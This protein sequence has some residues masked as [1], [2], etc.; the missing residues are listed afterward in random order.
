MPRVLLVEDE[1]D[2]RDLYA[3]YLREGGYEVLE[4]EDGVKGLDLALEGNWDIM[5]LDIML[6]SQDGIAVLKKIKS[7]PSVMDK[8]IIALTNLWLDSVINEMFDIG[9]DG[10]LIKSEIT[11]D[12]II[13]EIEAI[14]QKYS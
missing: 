7:T 5:L 11:P 14:L 9:V 12:K 4:A 1:K 10:Y 13:A 6:P 2:I 3:Q 8:P